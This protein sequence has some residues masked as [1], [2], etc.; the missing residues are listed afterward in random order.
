MVGHA[1]DVV[2]DDNVT[3]SGSSHFFVGGRHGAGCGEV[4]VEEFFEAADGTVAVFGN[5]CVIVD[6]GKEEALEFGIAL[7]GFIAETGE[8]LGSAANVFGGGNTDGTKAARRRF[9]QIGGESVQRALE[10]FIEFELAAARRVRAIHGAIGFREDGDFIEQR[11]EIKQFGFAGV[12]EVGG[13]VRDFV[14]AV[15]E[16][17]FE[18]RAEIEEIFREFRKLQRRIVAGML[19]DALA[20]LEGEIEAGEIEIAMLELLDDAEGMEVVVE[21]GTVSAHQLIQL[22]FAGVA[23]RRVTDV[24]D[25]GKSFGEFGIAAESAGDGAGN[26]RDFERMREAIPKMIGIA[27]GEDLRLGFQAAKGPGMNDAIAIAGVFASVGMLGFREAAV[28][29][30]LS[31]H[32]PGSAWRI[33]FDEQLHAWRMARRPAVQILN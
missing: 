32:G 12:V 11:R 14:N 19:D 15:D 21:A 13:V 29:R 33:G 30:E 25:K 2:A 31:S 3:G 26:L 5:S 1:G 9:D 8:A 22:A 24:V 4:V 17:S 28:A 23:E 6:V 7:G 27:H 16:L 10:C 18:R 20:N